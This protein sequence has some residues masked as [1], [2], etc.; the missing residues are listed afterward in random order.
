MK[1]EPTDLAIIDENLISNYLTKLIYF[2]LLNLQI[3]NSS[4]RIPN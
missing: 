2:Y 3:F 4:I 1:N